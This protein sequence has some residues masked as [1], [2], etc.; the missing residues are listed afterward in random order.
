MENDLCV[1][2][3]PSLNLEASIGAAA[4]CLPAAEEHPDKSTVCWTAGW[5]QERV[6]LLFLAQF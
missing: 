5:G 6:Y 2:K 4:A 3:T 1:I